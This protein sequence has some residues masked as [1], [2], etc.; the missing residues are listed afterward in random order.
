MA[1]RIRNLFFRHWRKFAWGSSA[2]IVATLG[3]QL[4]KPY[5]GICFII[6][7]LMGI[8]ATNIKAKNAVPPK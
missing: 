4:E 2:A 1:K 7:A 3:G 5:S 8:I 6:S